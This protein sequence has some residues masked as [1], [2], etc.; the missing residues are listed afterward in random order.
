MVSEKFLTW[1][2]TVTDTLATSNPS[3]SNSA[4]GSATEAAASNEKNQMYVEYS[5]SEYKCQ[6]W[7][8]KHETYLSSS[9]AFQC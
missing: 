4:T 6:Q 5:I 3:A 7:Y 9:L 2:V 8:Y 1:D